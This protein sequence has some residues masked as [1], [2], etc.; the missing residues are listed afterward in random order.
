MTLP[1]LRRS[2]ARTTLLGVAALGAL[3]WAAVF[4][5]GVNPNSLLAQL[6]IIL[7]LTAALGVLAAALVL[8]CKLAGRVRRAWRTDDPD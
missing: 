3:I 5:L 8:V 4:R 7:L 1:G 2:P 6:L